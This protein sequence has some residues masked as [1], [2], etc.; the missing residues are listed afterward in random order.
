MGRA[1]RWFKDLLGFRKHRPDPPLP[2][3]LPRPPAASS[4]NNPPYLSPAEAA[5]LRS[6]YSAS[7]DHHDP[8]RFERA[9]AVA[10]ATA[11]AADAARAAAQAAAAVVRLTGGGRGCGERG[12]LAAAVRIQAVF[13][14]YLARKA[15]RALKALVK[16]QALARGY[17]VRKQ[18]AAA[19]RSMQAMLRAQASLR[20]LRGRG[21]VAGRDGRCRCDAPRLLE[22]FDEGRSEQTASSFPSRRL[23]SC[24]DSPQSDVVVT[25]DESPK[26]VE[27]DTGDRGTNDEVARHRP[28][29]RCGQAENRLEAFNSVLQ[30][31][32]FPRGIITTRVPRTPG[33]SSDWGPTGDECRFSTAASTP[34]LPS[35]YKD[36]PVTPSR[37]VCG[38]LGD[39][40]VTTRRGYMASTE[41]FSA[42][43]RSRSAPR[44]RPGGRRST[45]N[46]LMESRSSFTG[47]RMQRSCT[48]AQEVINFKDAIAR[49][50][51]PA[52]GTSRD[53]G[54]GDARTL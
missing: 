45:L 34:R 6:F 19:L 49:K 25:T 8:V 10:A 17:L 24:L 28:K 31:S 22:R 5:W 18:A 12:R 40:D 21:V 41:S 51:R 44:Q 29:S 33:D 36:V 35:G 39:G 20:S 16:L 4:C 48:R 46:E 15:L 37:S 54:R 42:K 14:G 38:G 27:V 11:A 30:S 50:L 43:S 7:G 52:D 26:I 53:V 23:S 47:V 3:D 9:F 13:R 1:F 2:D 32:P